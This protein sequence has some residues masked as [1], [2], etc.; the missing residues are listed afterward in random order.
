MSNWEIAVQG[1][2]GVSVVADVGDTVGALLA[3]FGPI[4][5]LYFV[6]SSMVEHRRLRVFGMAIYVAA[7]AHLLP[8]AGT[9][10]KRTISNEIVPVA[11]EALSLLGVVLLFKAGVLALVAWRRRRAGM[12]DP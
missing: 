1:L 10:G 2:L 6:C 8:R 5:F 9:L 7:V 4:L 11:I 3:V 12:L